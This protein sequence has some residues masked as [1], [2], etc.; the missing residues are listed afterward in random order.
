MTVTNPSFSISLA[1]HTSLESLCTEKDISKFFMYDTAQGLW[2][3]LA[4]GI[5]FLPANYHIQQKS[6]DFPL[7]LYQKEATWDQ[8]QVSY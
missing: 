4:E 1:D 3:T 7:K 6:E 5:A 2:Q 8:Q